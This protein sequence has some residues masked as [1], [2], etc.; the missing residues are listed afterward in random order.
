MLSTTEL[1]A[2]AWQYCWHVRHS[3]HE[4][5]SQ[6]KLV[7][8]P[9]WVSILVIILSAY[10]RSRPSV[11]ADFKLSCAH[12]IP[13][14]LSLWQSPRWTLHW[15]PWRW[16]VRLQGW[17]ECCTSVLKEQF[18]RSGKPSANFP[19]FSRKLRKLHMIHGCVVRVKRLVWF[20]TPTV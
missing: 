12:S 4:I 20:K 9:P 19:G 11:V 7:P 10:S 15:Q 18:D 5:W 6:N 8:P 14:G 17:E 3:V 13:A 1:P 2:D 16:P